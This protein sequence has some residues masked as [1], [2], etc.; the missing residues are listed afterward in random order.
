[1]LFFA[2][3]FFSGLGLSAHSSDDSSFKYLDFFHTVYQTIKNDYV[4]Q[5]SPKV[6]FEGA[7]RGMLQSLDDPYTR[8]LDEAEYSEFKEEVT[9]KFIGI[10]VEVSMRDGEVVV[11]SPIEDSPAKRVGIKSGD[12]ILKIDDTY[13]RGKTMSE[14]LKKMKGEP[15]SAVKMTIRRNDFPEPLEFAIKREPVRR[16][17][18]RSGLM[19]ENPSVGYLR[20]THFYNETAADTEKALKDF[21]AKKIGRIVLDLRDNPGGDMEAAIRISNLFLD[22][23]K[24]IVS[25]RGREGSNIKEEYKAEQQPIYTGNLIVLVNGGSASASELLS[26]ALRDNKRAKLIGQKTFGKALV[27]RMID[28]DN[29]KTGFTLTIRKYYTPSGEMIHKKGIM[30][31]LVLKENDVSDADRKN[32]VRAINDRLF[33]EFVKQNPDYTEQNRTKLSTLLREKG[34]PVSDRVAAYFFKQEVVRYKPSRLYDLEFDNEL[35]RALE[36]YK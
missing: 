36:E 21:N 34:L 22:K 5:S 13:T 33:E 7:I 6:L 9:G 8:F 16:S 28:I 35:T 29:D 32:L 3:G 24:I 19:T 2:V 18:V 20:I 26:G 12:V 10:G 25:T 17:S 23:G 11:V 4:E 15:G 1:V 31:D 27:Q 14:I 30:P